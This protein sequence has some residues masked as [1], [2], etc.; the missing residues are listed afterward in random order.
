MNLSD[1]IFAPFETL[2][3]PLYLPITKIPG[4]GPF[5]VVLHFAKMFT[6]VLAAVTVNTALIFGLLALRYTLNAVD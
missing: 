3:K 6:G 2:I 1:R 4:K 5:F